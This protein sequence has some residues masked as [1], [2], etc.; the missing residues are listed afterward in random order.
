MTQSASPTI[1]QL[2][3]CCDGTN[4]TL[5]GRLADTNVLQ[6]F[7]AL[8]GARDAQQVLYYDPGVGAPDSLPSIGIGDWFSR[9]WKR[10][11][12]LASGRGVFDN[13]SMA[14]QF[15]VEHYRPGDQIYLF[16]FSR[17]AFTVRCVAG[18]INLFGLIR[19]EHAVLLPTLL[20]VYFSKVGTDGIE[21]GPMK[22]LMPGALPVTREDVAAQ[23]RESFTSVETRSVPVQFVG[24]W[25]TVASVGLPPFA[26]QIS[27]SATVRGK[28]FRHVRQALALD[29]HRRS[30][31][32]RVFSENNF[33][34]ADS[35]QSLV[36]QWF[37]GVHCD[38]GGGYRNGESGL[39]IVARDWMID[40]ARRCGLRCP[41]APAN[42]GAQALAHDPLFENALWAVTGMGARDTHAAVGTDGRGVMVEPVAHPANTAAA[43][44]SVWDAARSRLVLLI[45]LLTC[46]G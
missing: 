26:L 14:Y 10:L 18:M 16:G 13:I 39:S 37:R 44:A 11:S 4:K 33:G 29:E 20:Q 21:R 23:I 28:C 22:A 3:I 41:A 27:S 45:L 24:V 1:R 8:A 25:D 9:K 42:H 38:V 31:L 40:E 15:V 2:V 46:V 36:Q 7:E 17:G 32:P 30:F 12:G 43:V 6:V 19:A 35:P 34:D 5:T